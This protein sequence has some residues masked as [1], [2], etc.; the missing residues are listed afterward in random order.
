[1][2][3]AILQVKDK[4]KSNKIKKYI[5]RIINL[6]QARKRHI[7]ASKPIKVISFMAFTVALQISTITDL[8]SKINKNNFIIKSKQNLY[9][10]ELNDSS[11]MYSLTQ[12]KLKT[13]NTILTSTQPNKKQLAINKKLYD[14]MKN[15]IFKEYSQEELNS[16]IK[17]PTAKESK[18]YKRYIKRKKQ[19]NTIQKFDSQKN[20]SD[21]SETENSI[22]FEKKQPIRQKVRNLV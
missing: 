15:G 13:D 18:L 19:V 11:D 9:P 8:K 5:R 17:K 4:K 10:L 2:Q 12:I 20:H 6:L 7:K 1:V 3:R 16:E 21:H 14:D 22:I